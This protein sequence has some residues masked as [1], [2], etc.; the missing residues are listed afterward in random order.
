MRKEPAD[1]L[2]EIVESGNHEQA[3]DLFRDWTARRLHDGPANWDIYSTDE[4]RVDKWVVALA[5]LP[6]TDRRKLFD[7]L[8]QT[9]RRDEN[10]IESKWFLH[11]YKNSDPTGDD[12]DVDFPQF[13]HFMESPLIPLR[14]FGLEMVLHTAQTIESKDVELVGLFH[15]LVLDKSKARAKK[16]LVILEKILKRSP[17]LRAEILRLFLAGAEHE[18]AD[19]QSTAIKLL[20][21]YRDEN[22]TGVSEEFERIVPLLA[23][24]V[25]SEFGI[26]T[27]VAKTSSEGKESCEETAT[28]VISRIPFSPLQ[29]VEE[30]LALA[31]NLLETGG[32][33]V[34]IERF[35]DGVSRLYSERIPNWTEKTKPLIKR[36]LDLYSN[37]NYP[38]LG[39]DVN[40]YVMGLIAAWLHAETVDFIEA[41]KEMKTKFRTDNTVWILNSVWKKS[42]QPAGKFVRNHFKEIAERIR[43]GNSRQLLSTPTHGAFWI[44]PGVLVERVRQQRDG[45]DQTGM[46]DRLLALL[47]LA[48]QGRDKALA[49]LSENMENGST[50]YD[51][52]CRA[53]KIA[54]G[55][56]S[57]SIPSTED[58]SLRSLFAVALKSRSA[59]FPTETC[60]PMSYNISV[61][62][63]PHWL[64][65]VPGKGWVGDGAIEPRLILEPKFPVERQPMLPWTA[66]HVFEK[67]ALDPF[68]DETELSRMMIEALSGLC[69][70][71]MEPYCGLGCRALTVD[72]DSKTNIDKN[73]SFLPPLLDADVSLGPMGYSL[74][75]VAFASQAPPVQQFGIDVFLKA[76]SD[77]RF[78]IDDFVSAW[79]DLFRLDAYKS[80]RWKKSL[81]ICSKESTA[82][83][84]VVQRILELGLGQ[85]PDKDGANEFVELL[86]ELTV[87]I[88]TTVSHPQT[89]DFLKNIY[90]TGKS[91]KIAKKLLALKK[92]I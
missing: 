76:V 21:K 86:Y 46:H 34:D 40:F 73:P 51:H 57:D 35:L 15:R 47:R 78:K 54:F 18:A 33:S 82:H 26:E 45:F 38:A 87:A 11:I 62:R 22:E 60:S 75:C 6:G 13:V 7:I 39:L 66:L 42:S 37:R 31:G 50:D 65:N 91:A 64:V 55:D 9:A 77:G 59:I 2:R 49:I 30:L 63:V 32:S 28:L 61:N 44:D 72:I 8:F 58:E 27:D 19:V 23:P 10:D 1:Y 92:T 3:L 85:I 68:V 74:I 81:A 20:N 83:A 4:K 24:S 70:S 48:K 71:D 88:G 52:Y 5:K 16:S 53:L 36:L 41:S 29:S 90:G 80:V 14:T 79:I 84:E 67:R 56:H 25:K 17:S 69:P 89:C 43:N 12:L